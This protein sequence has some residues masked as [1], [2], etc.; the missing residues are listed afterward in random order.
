M[1]ER[2]VS[3]SS[4]TATGPVHSSDRLARQLI[5]HLGIAGAT[6]TCRE[7]H[8]DGVLLAVEAHARAV[9]QS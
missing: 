6:R 3:D 7:N 8:W 5:R 1:Q 4:L 2:N 9:A